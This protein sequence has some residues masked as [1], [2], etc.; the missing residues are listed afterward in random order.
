MVLHHLNS[1]KEYYYPILQTRKLAQ[2][3]KAN[4]H[5]LIRGDQY[6]NLLFCWHHSCFVKISVVS[7]RLR[8]GTQHGIWAKG[9]VVIVRMRILLIMEVITNIYWV[10]SIN[11]F[12]KYLLSSFWVR[13]TA[14]GTGN[15]AYSTELTFLWRRPHARP[16]ELFLLTLKQHYDVHPVINCIQWGNQRG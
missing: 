10:L 4:A 15:A 14:M 9:N 6:L 13:G 7:R 1:V 11:L 3:E 12:N 8:R 16:H 5:G 2:R